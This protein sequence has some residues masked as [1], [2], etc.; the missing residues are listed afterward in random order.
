VLKIQ[1]VRGDQADLVVLLDLEDP[2]RLA[3]PPGREGRTR[4]SVLGSADR[5]LQGVKRQSRAR[6]EKVSLF[7]I[8]GSRALE[9]GVISR[10]FRLSSQIGLCSRQSLPASPALGVNAYTIISAAIR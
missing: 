4:P 3:L 10:C 8:S 5:G 6:C 1:G 2:P 9:D 7:R